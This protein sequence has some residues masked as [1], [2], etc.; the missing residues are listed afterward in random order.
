MINSLYGD[1]S[2]EVTT[3]IPNRLY[4]ALIF[5]KPIIAS[6][7]TFLGEVVEKNRLGIAVEL[8]IQSIKKEVNNYVQ[9]FDKEE[10][11]RNCNEC[12]EKVIGEQNS[13]KYS[14]RE[15]LIDN[16]RRKF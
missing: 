8:N 10:F 2:L 3:A 14:I 16:L 4:D 9:N 12:L 13:F 11:I 6:K 5:K 15:F 1:F 7:G